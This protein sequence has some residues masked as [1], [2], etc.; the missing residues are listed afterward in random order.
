[1]YIYVYIYDI[2]RLR[3]KLLPTRTQAHIRQ[4][5]VDTNNIIN[6]LTAKYIFKQS[7]YF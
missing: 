3:V 2:S 1:M 6:T 5:I 7:L 4:R